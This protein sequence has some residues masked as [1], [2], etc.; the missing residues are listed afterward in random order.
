MWVFE[1]RNS[2]LIIQHCSRSAQLVI[3]NFGQTPLTRSPRGMNS[4]SISVKFSPLLVRGDE[5]AITEHRFTKENCCRILQIAHNPISN[6][7]DEDVPDRLKSGKPIRYELPK[8]NISREDE[9]CTAQCE[10][11][12]E[13]NSKISPPGRLSVLAFIGNHPSTSP[14]NR[15]I[16]RFLRFHLN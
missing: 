4:R 6:F 9:L 5:N 16:V 3:H 13:L 1:R 2:N 15:A 11:W 14:R 8:D 12:P 7:Q 10:V